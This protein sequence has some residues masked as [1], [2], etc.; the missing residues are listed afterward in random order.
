MIEF[1]APWCG[2]CKQL[3]P[4]YTEAASKLKGQVRLGKVD[5]TVE[6]DLA[7]RFGVRGYPSIKV[8]DYGLGNKADSKAIDYKG[9]RTAAGIVSYMSNLAEK[10]NIEP[11]IYEMIN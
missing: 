10:A 6:T 11:D 4:E 3:E 1:Y 9:E 5:A 7:T 2:H 8:F